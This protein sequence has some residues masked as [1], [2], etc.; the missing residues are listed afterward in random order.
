MRHRLVYLFTFGILLG[1]YGQKAPQQFGVPNSSLANASFVLSGR[2]NAEDGRPISNVSIWVAQQKKGT[3]S[4]AQGLFSLSL[5]YGSHRLR[6]EALGFATKV[7]N[8]QLYASGQLAIEMEEAVESLE[9][10]VVTKGGNENINSTMVGKSRLS[11]LETQNI[12]F[13]LGEQNLL[14][15]ATVL[16]GIS[17][18]GEA[19]TGFNV[20]GG[21]ADQNLL[22]LNKGILVNPNHFFGIFQALNPFVVSAL[23]VYKGNI[24]I[25][26]EGRTSSVFEMTTKTPAT[27]KVR[28]QAS[29]GP[30]TANG[31][32]EV[33]VQKGQSGLLVGFRSAHSDWILRALN[34]PKL[35]KSSA[36]FYDGILS[37]EDQLTPSDRLQATYYISNDAFQIS[38]DSLFGY[39]NRLAAVNWRHRIKEG[40]VM[41]LH[42]SS[43][44]YDFSITYDGS[45]RRNFQTDFKIDIQSLRLQFKQQI[46][47][48][49]TLTYGSNAVLY[50]I[51][52]GSIRPL[53]ETD[54]IRSQELIREKAVEGSIYVA[55]QIEL[56]ERWLV[57][58]GLQMALYGALGPYEEKTYQSDLPKSE[59][60]VLTQ[61]Q[62][63]SNSFFA[64]QFFP[65][66]RL[67]S[68]YKF[69]DVFALKFA[70]LRMYQFI[71]SLTNNTTASPIDTWRIST[72][73]L[74]PQKSDQVTLGA[75]FTPENQVMEMSLEGFYKDQQ[76]LVDF[77]TGANLFLNQF[78]ETEVLQGRGKAYGIEFLLR[79]KKGKHTGWLG[80][81]FARTLIQLESDFLEERVNNGVYFPTNY[82][83]PHDLSI[84]WNYAFHPKWNC[85]ANLIYQTGR[86]I[87][88]PN[89]NYVFNNAEYV[90]F[91]DRNQY[92]IPDYYRVDLGLNYLGNK[93][94]DKAIQTAWRVSVYN[95]LGRN[96]PFSVYF[97]SES[98]Q[99]QGRQ[100]GIFT[101]PIPSITCNVSF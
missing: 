82:D 18:A 100:S 47:A 81:T 10:V 73:N 36:S 53:A 26:Y 54:L 57:N 49:H 29:I 9:E 77:K 2:I 38:S 87:T 40:H 83:R 90:L 98:G 94:D 91:S 79:K 35:Q 71:H 70:A 56:S 63:P 41:Q 1:L 12:P 86:P 21:K 15:A 45:A 48:Q 64:Q 19:A 16:P 84:V 50:G 60:T 20:R 68:R 101:V 30:I 39:S 89:G 95:V 51:A 23:N 99:I 11:A 85:N 44:A 88:I 3:I 22:L 4:D 13:V 75:F 62:L 80:Y 97:I 96:N 78:I 72:N 58:L 93:K 61:V 55:D 33:P 66:Y 28:G 24:P 37:Y 59:E 6:V 92:R 34:D 25:E 42:A 32:L 65:S 52:P 8:L 31:L 74:A 14:K 5:P 69:N 43:S 17:T 76:N 7:I 27:D 67:A 46:N